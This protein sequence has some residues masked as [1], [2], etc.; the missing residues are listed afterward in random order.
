MRGIGSKQLSQHGICLLSDAFSTWISAGRE[1]RV[2]SS[3]ASFGSPFLSPAVE[4]LSR[5][6]MPRAIAW[7]LL[8]DPLSRLHAEWC[9]NSGRPTFQARRE[10]QLVGRPCLRSIAGQAH[11]VVALLEPM[12]ACMEYNSHQLKLNHRATVRTC[13]VM[14]RPRWAGFAS[15]WRAPTPS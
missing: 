10:Q 15:S 5:N 11:S 2:G 3:S 8:L 9:L 7:A 12:V 13:F 1:W 14:R 6:G 4:K